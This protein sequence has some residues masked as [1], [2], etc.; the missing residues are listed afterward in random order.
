MASKQLNM[1]FRACGW[2]V[3]GFELDAVT[4]ASES[5]DPDFLDFMMGFR[6]RRNFRFLAF[7]LSV[8]DDSSALKSLEFGA[9]FLN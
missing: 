9:A 4:V 8:C 1:N 3:L 2:N 6:E 7:C 5:V